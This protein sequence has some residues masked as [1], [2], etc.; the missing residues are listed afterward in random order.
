MRADKRVRNR[1][2]SAKLRFPEACIEDIDFATPR[3][4]DRRST[5]PLAQ[6]EWLKAHENLIVTG[7]PAP[8]SHGCPFPSGGK[9]HGSIIAC[10]ICAYRACS[11][12]WRSPASM[13]ASPLIDKFTASNCSFSTTSEPAASPTSSAST[14]RNRRGKLSAKSHHH[15]RLALGSCAQMA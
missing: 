6:G 10:S 5:M 12:I 11:K 14:V 7:K 1:L 8:A 15:H 13:A 4:L 9:R 3:G 2:A